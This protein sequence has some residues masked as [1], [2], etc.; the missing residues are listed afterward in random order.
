MEIESTP[1][2]GVEIKKDTVDSLDAPSFLKPTA[3]GITPQEHKGK[4]VPI[5]LALR[6]DPKLLL[7]RCLA[8]LRLEMNSWIN[9]AK[10]NP[11]N[12]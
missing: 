1:V 6:I 11:N 9:P 8:N 3:V 4:G 10:K 12:R 5:K 2:S 7:P